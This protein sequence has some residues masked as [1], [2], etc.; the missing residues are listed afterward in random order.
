[1]LVVYSLSYHFAF[2][3]G[4]RADAFRYAV[5]GSD[6]A[7]SRGAHTDAITLCQ[8]AAGLVNNVVDCNIIIAVINVAIQ[9]LKPAGVVTDFMKRIRRS[10]SILAGMALSTPN[11]PPAQTQPFGRIGSFDTSGLLFSYTELKNHLLFKIAVYKE[12][13]AI[14]E[15]QKAAFI[16]RLQA[17]KEWNCVCC[18]SSAVVPSKYAATT[19]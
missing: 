3:P 18:N 19:D 11:E 5:E 2:A 10:S 9:Q 4:R 17:D 16:A 6:D 1:M 12:E 14:A 8:K 13:E 7:I 15:S